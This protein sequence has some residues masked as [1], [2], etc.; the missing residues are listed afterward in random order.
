M[1]KNWWR[2]IW[3]SW[4]SDE[5]DPSD[6]HQLY[7]CA[8]LLEAFYLSGGDPKIHSEFRL[9]IQRFGLTPIDRRRLEWKVPSPEEPEDADAPAPPTRPDPRIMPEVSGGRPN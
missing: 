6:I 9:A 1:V 7:P 3:A 8:F 4:M 2:D 5:W